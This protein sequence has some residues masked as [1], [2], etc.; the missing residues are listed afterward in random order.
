MVEWNVVSDLIHRGAWY[1]N[2]G[3]VLLNLCLGLALITSTINGF[4]SSVL[5]GLQILPDWQT[6]FQNPGGTA[7]GEWSLGAPPPSGAH[8]TL[9]SAQV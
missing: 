7:L 2:R 5:N 6:Y 1:S 9:S 8:E 4:D 3:I